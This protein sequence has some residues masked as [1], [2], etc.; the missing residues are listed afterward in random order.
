M[1]RKET[2]ESNGG[3]SGRKNRECVEEKLPLEVT[4]GF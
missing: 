1:L 3:V 4:Q 2:K